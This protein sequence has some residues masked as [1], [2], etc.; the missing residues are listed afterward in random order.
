MKIFRSSLATV[1]AAA[2]AFTCSGAVYADDDTTEL[3][4]YE[5]TTDNVKTLG[6]TYYDGESLWLSHSATGV[7][8]TFTGSTV[9]ATLTGENGTR[10][11]IYS[12][13]ERVLDFMTSSMPGTVTVELEE[14]EHTISILKLSEAMQSTVLIDSISVD[15]DEGISPTSAKSKKIEFIGD[16]ITCGYGIDGASASES[17][18]TT[19]E[20]GARTYAYKT[21]QLFN[22]DYSMVSVSGCGIVSGYTG[23][24]GTAN[25]ANLMTDFYENLGHAWGWFHDTYVDAIEWDFDE[26]VPDLIV[27]NLGTNDYSYTGS[28]EDLIQE[29]TDG[30]VEFLK[31]VRENN[32][33][34]EILCTLGIMGQQ[35]YSAME[36]AVANYI[37]ETGDTKVNTLE[38]DAIDSSTEGYG[39]DYHP[40]ELT[41]EKAAYTLAEKINELYGWE[42]DETVDITASEEK[43]TPLT[44]IMDADEDDD[45]DKTDENLEDDESSDDEDI[46]SDDEDTSE[47]ENSEEDEASDEESDEDSSTASASTSSSASSTTSSSSSSSN[48]SNPVTGAAGAACAAAVLA[49]GVFV[50]VKKAKK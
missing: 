26:Y 8:F 1:C 6:R 2:I 37:E 13:G 12:D 30:Y 38:F 35:L 39:S 36:T 24:A 49:V 16:S 42:I 21:A 14:G 25:T 31:Q 4:A 22:A 33:D 10:M 29:Y 50:A 3:T 17:F 11:A 5:A 9:T 32:P 40:T 28:D 7:E 15:S 23:S 20:D 34:S 18:S 47:D 43:L 19:T 48:D 45:S 27:I 46:A 41:H 44:G